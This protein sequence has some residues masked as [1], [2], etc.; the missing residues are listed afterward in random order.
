[1]R[2][3]TGVAA[4]AL[5]GA[6]ACVPAPPTAG[7]ACALGWGAQDEVVSE[8]MSGAAIVDVRAG[9]HDCFDRVVVD[10]DGTVVPGYAARYVDAVRQ[11]GSGDPIALRGGAF[12]ELV[13]RAPAIDVDTGTS[14]FPRAGSSELVDVSGFPAL[15]QVAWAG[16]QEGLTELG[17]GVRARL[18][19]RVLTLSGPGARIRVVV[20]IAHAWG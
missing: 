15:R 3:W 9:V 13:V 10:A 12:L 1:M 19:F 4:V 16:Y 20:D 11:I 7:P 8:P 2:A 5:A 18:P 17:L 14:T 6:T